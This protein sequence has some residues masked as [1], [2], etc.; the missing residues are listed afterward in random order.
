MV[1]EH[2]RGP[3]VVGNAKESEIAKEKRSG[4]QIILDDDQ[5]GGFTT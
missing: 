2:I 4:F 3:P 1:S 5:P